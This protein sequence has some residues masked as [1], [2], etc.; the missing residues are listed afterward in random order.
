MTEGMSQ[1]P[2]Q[3]DA[4]ARNGMRDRA[5]QAFYRFRQSPL[6]IVGLALAVILLLLS[7]FG[8]WIVP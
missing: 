1:G 3:P 2:A 6:T 4:P 8:P 5:A 7:A